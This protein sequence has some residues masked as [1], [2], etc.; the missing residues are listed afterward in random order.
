[1]L[2]LWIGDN[3]VL[4][5]Q[6]LSELLNCSMKMVTVRSSSGAIND[7]RLQCLEALKLA[8]KLQAPSQYVH[9]HHSG[10]D[11][12]VE[13][14]TAYS[15]HSC[16]L[17]SVLCNAINP[18]YIMLIM[19]FMVTD[20]VIQL[21]IQPQFLRLRFVM[22]LLDCFIFYFCKANSFTLLGCTCAIDFKIGNMNAYIL[23]NAVFTLHL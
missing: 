15:G 19:H 18:E 13:K 6:L 4:K 14:M 2:I 7:A 9:V 16:I 20:C 8:I 17:F 1:M 3:L 23:S 12:W 11:V 22:V 21:L 10:L 5:W